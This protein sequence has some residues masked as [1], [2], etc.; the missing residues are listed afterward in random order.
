MAILESAIIAT[1]EAVLASEVVRKW[2]GQKTMAI[3][4]KRQLGM[5]TLVEAT[6]VGMVDQAALAATSIAPLHTAVT[7]LTSTFKSVVIITMGMGTR[8][9]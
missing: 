8:G 2:T 5:M 4:F 3:V 9:K 7:A 1:R 6:T